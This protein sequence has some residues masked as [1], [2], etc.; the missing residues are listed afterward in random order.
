MPGFDTPELK[1]DGTIVKLPQTLNGTITTGTVAA[2][3]TYTEEVALGG[4][5]Y[6]GGVLFLRSN[7]IRASSDGYQGLACNIRPSNTGNAISSVSIGSYPST[8]YT[9]SAGG[10]ASDKF[11]QSSGG[12]LYL[13]NAYIDGTN[14]DIMFYNAHPTT[15]ASGTIYYTALVW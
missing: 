6:T 5:G 15:S 3:T 4:S 2:R 9:A 14:L 1:I 7:N 10:Q 8:F 13:R 11:F 12:Q